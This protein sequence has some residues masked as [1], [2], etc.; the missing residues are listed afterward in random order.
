[1]QKSAAAAPLHHLLYGLEDWM[2][3]TTTRQESE[4]VRDVVSG[5]L[6]EDAISWIAGNMDPEDVF[7]DSQLRQWAD[8]NGLVESDE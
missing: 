1:L 4:F 2:M 8:E 6:L 5:T 7:S 3:M